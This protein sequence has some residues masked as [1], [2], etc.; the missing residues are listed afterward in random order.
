MDI[1]YMLRKH[2]EKKSQL[3]FKTLDIEGL[4]K[5][6]E[7]HNKPCEETAEEIIESLSMPAVAISDMPKSRTNKFSSPTENVMFGY[8]ENPP[9]VDIIDIKGRIYRLKIDIEPVKKD[10]EIVE[11]FL[12][13]LS[14]EEFLV[15]NEHYVYNQKWDYV[16]NA[17]YERF[18][19]PRH[20]ETLKN[21]RNEAFNKMNRMIS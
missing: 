12:A 7:Y 19:Q 2:L 15:I 9:E 18:R 6:L 17:Y 10:V 3:K 14:K 1:E 8:T 16:A 21:I 13:G 4:E 11:C 5:I 20:I